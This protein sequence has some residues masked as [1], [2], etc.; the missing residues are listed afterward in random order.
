MLQGPD[1][2]TAKAAPRLY[3]AIEP[4]RRFHLDVGDGHALYVELCGKPGGQPVLVLHGG[5]GA[6]ISPFMR[7]FFNPKRYRI[8]LFDQ[9]GT[10]RSTP[11]GGLEANTSWHLVGD[12]ERLREHLEIETWH[13]FGGS[14]GSTLALL[15]A[16]AH[17][18]RV[19]ALV[20]RG[21]FTMTRAELDWFYGGGAARFFPE[22][23]KDFTGPIPV[24]ERDDLIGAYHRRLT[25]PDEALQ[26]RFARPWVRW[27]TATAS[28]RPNRAGFIDGAYARAFAR[29]ESH[30]FMHDGWLE[31]DGQILR[32]MDRIAHVPGT[33]IQGRYDMICP[34][35]TAQALIA[36]WPAG[37]LKIVED[38]GHALS[39]PGIAAEL[40]RATDRFSQ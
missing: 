23:W 10:G 29:I 33:L 2:T 1:T 8:I 35:A 26:L 20:L 19:T 22:E 4:D 17:P 14:W 32:D 5:P 34:P 27:E 31:E 28:L 9:R 7:R 25:D 37:T 39:E 30:Y 13:V 38:G 15:Y 18:D 16:Q 6:G 40:I 36:R 12:I 11:R 21:L 24:A 3:P